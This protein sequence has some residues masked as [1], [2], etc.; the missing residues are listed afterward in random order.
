[1]LV[2]LNYKDLLWSFWPFYINIGPID[3]TVPDYKT[4][5]GSYLQQNFSL[6]CERFH[7]GTFEDCGLE[8]EQAAL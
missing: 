3:H 8:E 1:M 5:K 4:V 6:I 7:E 2:F